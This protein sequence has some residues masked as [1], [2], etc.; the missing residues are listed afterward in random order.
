MERELYLF[1]QSSDDE[2][3]WLRYNSLMNDGYDDDFERQL[4]R[5]KR[6]RKHRSQ[7]QRRHW[8]TCRPHCEKEFKEMYRLTSEEFQSLYRLVLSKCPNYKGDRASRL[9]GRVRLA[10]CLRFLAG[11][12]PIDVRRLH[13]QSKRAF[14]GDLEETLDSLCAALPYATKWNDENE[15]RALARSCRK[16]GTDAHALHGVV[17]YVDGIIVRTMQPTSED[18]GG[19]VK[20]FW[21]DRK[22][23]YGLNVQVVCDGD[24]KIRSLFINTGGGTADSTAFKASPLGRFCQDGGLR[25]TYFLVGDAAY[26]TVNGVLCPY[27]GSHG[28]DSLKDVFN[29]VLSGKRAAI[30][31]A[32]GCLVRR[33]GV[34]WRSLQFSTRLNIKIVRVVAKLH[35]FIIDCRADAD[36]DYSDSHDTDFGVVPESNDIVCEALCGEYTHEESHDPTAL[37]DIRREIAV[38]LS[39]AGFCRAP[40]NP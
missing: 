11:G 14:F 2:D 25:D 23:C 21:C 24:L 8:E 20:S 26:R 33:W 31:R 17:G 5:R 16:A 1:M 10:S 36:F 35:N 6:V 13:G 38:A 15:L 28:R 3:D 12:N 40:L 39:D 32:L 37:V 34:L 9:D 22:K 7:L 4:R 27:A 18:C 29:Y 30:E 19:N